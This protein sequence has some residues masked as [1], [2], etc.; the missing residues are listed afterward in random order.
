MLKVKQFRYNLDN[1]GY[2]IYG[3]NYAIAIDGGAVEEIF[4]F[5]ASR[6]LELLFVAN[7]HRHADH[8]IGNRYLLNESHAR[9]LR[10]EEIINVG[11]I[12]LEGQNITIYNTPG[13]TDDSVCFHFDVS[14]ITGDTLFNGTVGNCFSGNLK[15]FYRSI[16]NIMNLSQDTIIY[17]GHDYVHDSMKY[18]RALEPDNNDI[19]TFL[20]NYNPNHVFSTLMEELKINP[21][22]RFNE[23]SIIDLLKKHGLPL[24]TEL[25]RWQSLMAME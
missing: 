23:N 14:L 25:Q 13:H 12:E 1:L 18:A 8:T 11:A 5:T 10:Y 16:K 19:E 7:T 3:L 17:P 2:L 9:L 21:Y 24:K 22:L 6:K 20:N 4:T 15:N